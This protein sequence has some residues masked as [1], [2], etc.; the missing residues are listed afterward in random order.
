MNLQ[1]VRPGDL[2]LYG[3]SGLAFLFLVLP[4]LIVM[5]LSFSSAPYLEFPPRGFSLQWYRSYFGSPLW[6]SST[7]RSIQVAVLVTVLATAVGT[8]AALGLVRCQVPGRRLLNSLLVSPLVI[9]TIVLSISIYS[10]FVQWKLLGTIFGLV[11]AHSVLA[12]PFVIINVS[13]TLYG[14][15]PTLEKAALS[16]GASPWT[17]FWR[18]LLPTIRPGV[19][20][21]ALFAFITSFDEI[22]ISM[23]IAGLKPTLP[24]QMFDGIRF[25]VSPT[26]TA[27]STILILIS[28]LVLL[29]AT[30]AHRRQ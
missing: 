30:L 14:V 25:E 2:M 3:F 6:I 23:F 13:A 4:S 22:V 8:A 29:A 27:V 21:G 7:F 12:I 28:T 26:L 18:V 5:V 16:M 10:V 9:P 17:T 24:K 20:A 19:I 11:F 1:R 15:D